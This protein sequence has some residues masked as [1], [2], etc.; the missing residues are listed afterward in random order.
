M[1]RDSIRIVKIVPV[2]LEERMLVF[3]MAPLGQANCQLNIKM[4]LTLGFKAIKKYLWPV[5][6]IASPYN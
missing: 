2:S 6:L 1:V 4:K 5:L 3:V